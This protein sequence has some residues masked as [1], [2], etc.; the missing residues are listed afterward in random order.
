MVFSVHYRIVNKYWRLHVKKSPRGHVSLVPKFTLFVLIL[1]LNALGSLLCPFI[2]ILV[3][4][5]HL[6]LILIHYQ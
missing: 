6:V 4:I 2:V 3:Y 1:A 5:K